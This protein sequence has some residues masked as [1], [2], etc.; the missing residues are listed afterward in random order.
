MILFLCALFPPRH[1]KLAL[2]QGRGLKLHSSG[3]SE[4]KSFS[5]FLPCNC[6]TPGY[7]G[8]VVHWFFR[9]VET[10][11]MSPCRFTQLLW[12]SGLFSLQ[13]GWKGPPEPVIVL[14]LWSKPM[15]HLPCFHDSNPSRF[16]EWWDL[17]HLLRYHVCDE[18]T[19]VWLLQFVGESRS[20]FYEPSLLEDDKET[21]TVNGS[22]IV[23]LVN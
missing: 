11:S 19:T 4:H 10:P 17:V 8:R 2:F 5:P 3:I 20:P 7:K 16:T 22:R 18:G 12:S 6:S 15:S 23:V 14:T 21:Q 1:C 9:S 13:L